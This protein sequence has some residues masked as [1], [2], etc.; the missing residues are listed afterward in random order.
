MRRCYW[1]WRWK[2][3]KPCVTSKKKNQMCLWYV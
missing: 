2:G 1:K 3:G